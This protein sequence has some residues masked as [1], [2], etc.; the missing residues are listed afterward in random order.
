[1]AT[2]I[3]DQAIAQ[4]CRRGGLQLRINGRAD[5]QAAFIQFLLA[6]QADQLA[7]DFFGEIG[8]RVI[9]RLRA[10]AQFDRV[11]LR[12]SGHGGGE[13]A[14]R[15]HPIDHP[16]ATRPRAER[17]AFGMV[18]V[19]SFRQRAEKGDLSDRQ[20]LQRLVEIVQ[21]CGGDA[22]GPAAEI[23]F[24]QIQFENLVLRES[25]VDPVG[26]DSL[27]D[28]P[29]DRNL[30][31]QQEVLRDLLGDG[32]RA[33]QPFA[34]AVILQI[35]DDRPDDPGEIDPV[36]LIEALIFRGDERLLHPFGDHVDRNVEPPL[37]RIFRQ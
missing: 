22:I 23:D 36:M 3:G 25:L 20:L 33:D 7:A 5:G 15:H 2:V 16:V 30:I 24:I 12:V 11:Q 21:R 18:V 19:R 37:G 4:G 29:F 6:I 32:R 34:F 26:E 28:L 35:R 27:L 8:G 14:F 1:M 13:K 10:F 9:F 31:C 17:I